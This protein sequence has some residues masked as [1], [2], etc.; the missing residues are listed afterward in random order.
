[1]WFTLSQVH[2]SN[3]QFPVGIGF[4]Q[5]VSLILDCLKTVNV[6]RMTAEETRQWNLSVLVPF[7]QPPKYLGHFQRIISQ[8]KSPASTIEVSLFSSS[9]P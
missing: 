1:M 6:K 5:P 4:Y 2:S 7:M 9:A 3:D 8:L